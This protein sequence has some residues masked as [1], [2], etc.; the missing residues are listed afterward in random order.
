VD[1]HL[2][3]RLPRSATPWRSGVF[4]HR[5]GSGA[6]VDPECAALAKLSKTQPLKD[7]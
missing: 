7:G 1:A 5:V 2:H 3:R 6:D 4:S